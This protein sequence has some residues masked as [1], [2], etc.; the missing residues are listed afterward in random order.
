MTQGVI[1]PVQGDSMSCEVAS[2]KISVAATSQRGWRSEA[3][4]EDQPGVSQ[5]R[6]ETTG[7]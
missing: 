5:A 2:L 3:R 1:C 4:R 7:A 6:S